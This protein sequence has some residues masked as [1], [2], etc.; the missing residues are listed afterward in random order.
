MLCAFKARV[1]N[2]QKSHLLGPQSPL[3]VSSRFKVVFPF[4]AAVVVVLL[5]PAAQAVTLAQKAMEGGR[6]TTRSRYTP[7]QRTYCVSGAGQRLLLWRKYMLTPFDWSAE[8]GQ[9]SSL[10]VSCYFC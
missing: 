10:F 5:L 1:D 2:V 8:L 3:H 9:H 6:P 7:V 4:A